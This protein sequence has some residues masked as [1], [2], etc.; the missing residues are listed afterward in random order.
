MLDATGWALP[1]L[2]AQEGAE[3]A[4]RVTREGG[5]VRLE[6]RR[7]SDTCLLRSESPASAARHLFGSHLSLGGGWNPCV[8][9]VLPEAIPV[10]PTVETWKMLA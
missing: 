6:G 8:P 2:L 7:G 10:P 1:S 9:L 5:L 3:T 4:Y